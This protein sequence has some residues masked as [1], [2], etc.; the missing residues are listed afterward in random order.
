MPHKVSLARHHCHN[1]RYCVLKVVEFS[2]SGANRANGP[3]FFGRL[4]PPLICREERLTEA[5]RYFLCKPRSNLMSDQ[6]NQQNQQ[7]GQQG[8]GQ[9][10]GQQQQQPNQKPG[11]GGQQ[12]GGRNQNDPNTKP[13]TD[14]GTSRG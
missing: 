3:V 4:L 11:Q 13:G 2:C 14:R 9:K 7:G 10:P 8:G 1:G 6:R 12:Q 5:Q